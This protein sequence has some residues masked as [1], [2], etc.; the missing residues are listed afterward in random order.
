MRLPDCKVDLGLPE[1]DVEK[2]AAAGIRTAVIG[3]APTGGQIVD[4]WVPPLLELARAG[5]DIASGM[6]SK[7]VDIPE[8][9]MVAKICGARLIDIRVPPARLPVGRGVRRTGKRVLTVGTD[10]AVGKKYT[11]LALH[12]EL[13]NR[14]LPA[15]FRATGQTGIMI[16]GSGI[17]I[18]AVVADFISGAAEALSPD[19]DPDHWDVVEGQGTLLHPSYAGV[20]LGLVHGSQ[21]DAIVLCHHAGREELLGMEGSF[22][23][24]SIDEV[25]DMAL[26]A[27]HV[28]NPDCVCVGI[29]ANTSTMTDDERVAY[30][31]D[32]EHKYGLPCTD[33]IA[34]GMAKIADA[35]LE[36]RP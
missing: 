14:G 6:H 34:T 32:L 7:L 36:I 18:D 11:A 26:R 35:L 1:M 33:P 25:I 24:P 2:A 17:P 29:S 19:N 20:T 21:P 5:I 28:T 27:A 23:V 8:L 16:A 22:R 12:R 10:C 4:A 3:V 9:A 30:L 13:A 15:T 31:A